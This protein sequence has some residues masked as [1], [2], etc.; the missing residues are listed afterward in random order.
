MLGYPVGKKGT[1]EMR[2]AAQLEISNNPI[3]YT[4]PY[5][6]PCFKTLC[7]NRIIT[8]ISIVYNKYNRY[9]YNPYGSKQHNL[10]NTITISYNSASKPN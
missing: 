7:Q 8:D 9:D 10:D 2:R 6:N 3:K 5:N 4:R 1:S